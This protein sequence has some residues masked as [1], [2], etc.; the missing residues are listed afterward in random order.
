[1]Q[2]YLKLWGKLILVARTCMC[3][4]PC[5]DTT[6]D[7]TYLLGF[8]WGLAPSSSRPWHYTNSLN[9]ANHR[10]PSKTTSHSH[11]NPLSCSLCLPQLSFVRVFIYSVSLS[12]ILKGLCNYL[13]HRRI[14]DPLLH[15][16]QER[17]A[18]T[19]RPSHSDSNL[20]SRCS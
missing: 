17:V 12:E 8:R 11:W 10:K 6:C 13:D 3:C 5:F 19:L 15:S 1:M 9:L 14:V 4:S 2:Y 16:L 20:S 18:H 7:L